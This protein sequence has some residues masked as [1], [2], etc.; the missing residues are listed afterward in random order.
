[1]PKKFDFAALKEKLVAIGATLKA[2]WDAWQKLN[3]TP[4]P[5]P[6]M[7]TRGSDPEYDACVAQAVK[8]GLSQADAEEFVSREAAK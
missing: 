3:P 8:G 2:F 4:P 5:I 7:A 6:T 1:M